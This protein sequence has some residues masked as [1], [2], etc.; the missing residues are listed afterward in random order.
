MLQP[1]SVFS[2]YGLNLVIILVNFALAQGAMAWLDRK[3]TAS[4]IVAVESG[5]TRRWLV[6]TGV[7]LVAWI[8]VSLVI[9][10]SMPM[11]CSI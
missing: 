1:V 9:L 11:F 2:V 4:D 7:A 6:G 10:N 3:W 8:G 5:S